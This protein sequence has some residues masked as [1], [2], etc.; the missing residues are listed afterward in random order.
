MEVEDGTIRKILQK[1]KNE[2]AAG[3]DGIKN[4]MLIKG[5][6]QMKESLKRIFETITVNTQSIPEQWN[7]VT[8]KTF[9]RKENE[10]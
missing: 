4:E 1:S 8:I 9:I 2:K 7:E 6:E 10:Q 5:G 3:K